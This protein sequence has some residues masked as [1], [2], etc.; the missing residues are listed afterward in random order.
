M[1]IAEK[2]LSNREIEAVDLIVSAGR[3]ELIDA[4]SHLPMYQR[5]A[6]LWIG[7]QLFESRRQDVQAP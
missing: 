4:L 2:V 1:S 7:R 5:H 6:I 3:Q